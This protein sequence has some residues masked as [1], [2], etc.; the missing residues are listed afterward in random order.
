MI[1][2]ASLFA[3][4]Y[5]SLALSVLSL[6]YTLN[7]LFFFD[8]AAFVSLFHQGVSLSLLFP[9]DRPQTVS[10]ANIMADLYIFHSFSTLSVSEFG[11]FSRKIDLKFSANIVSFNFHDFIFL[12]CT[13]LIDFGFL[14]LK[15]PT[16]RR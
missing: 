3:L 11:I 2:S 4:L 15:H 7:A 12:S 8:V 13:T 5:S 6:K 9:F 10:A 1:S 16:T 14:I